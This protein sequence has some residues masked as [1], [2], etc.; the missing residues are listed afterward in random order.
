MAR[1]DIIEHTADTGIKAYGAT[2]EEAFANAAYGMF[3][4]IADPETVRETL[5]REINVEADDREALLVAWLNELLYVLDVEQLVFKRFTVLDLND[6]HLSAEA[7]GEPID[8]R[9]HVLRP[10]VKAA[11]FYMLRIDESDGVSVQVIFDI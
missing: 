6:T 4:L 11:T 5:S 3:T 2:L 7:H 9:R 1:F 10:G 8:T